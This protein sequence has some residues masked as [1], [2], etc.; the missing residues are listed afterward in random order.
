MTE[1]GMSPSPYVMT[2]NL[3]IIDHL[4]INLYSSIPAVISEA[5]A[6]AWDAD[7][8]TIEITFDSTRRA[9]VIGDNGCGMTLGEINTKFLTVGYRRRD[10]EPVRTPRDRHVM[11]RKGIGKLS[12]FSIAETIEVQTAKASEAGGAL[13]KNGLV[14]RTSE[15]REAAKNNLPYYPTPVPSAASLVQAGTR[16]ELTNLSIQPTA[17]TWAALRRRLARRFSVIGGGD[18]SIVVDGSP[19]QMS[20]RAYFEKV[21]YLWS[22]GDVGNRY[23]DLAT[24]KER[25]ETIDGTVD[26]GSG[27]SVRGWVGTFDERKDIDEAA[28]AVPVLAWGKLLHEDLLGEARA[29]GL[30]TKYLTGEIEAD[31]I[32]LDAEPD[33]VTSDRQRLKEDDPRVEALATWFRTKVL[34]QVGNSWRDW[35]RETALDSALDLPPI[36]DWYDALN[37][38]EK[39]FAKQLFGKIGTVTLAD[40]E[41]R[42]ELYR[43]AI[44]AF[45]RLRLKSQLSKLANLPEN[46][47]FAVLEAVFGGIDEIEGAQYHQIARVR[48][49]VIR[50]F[51]GI[52]EAEREKLIQR[53]LFGH[54]WLLDPSWERASTNARIEEAVTK[55]FDEVD[56]SLTEEERRGRVD[57]RYRTAAGKH[58]IIE[59]KKYDVSVDLSDLFRQLAK[60]R[61]AL[62]KCLTEKFPTEHQNIELIAILGKPPTGPAAT[63]ERIVDVLETLNA[64]YITYD[65]LIADTIRSYQDYLDADKEVSR[66]SDILDRLDMKQDEVSDADSQQ[67]RAGNARG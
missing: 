15:I 41:A 9:I 28:N 13:E 18:F 42:R 38:D 67:L 22:I 53:Y 60:Y 36:K 55:E 49:D 31:F 21:Q 43:H 51:V 20:E 58:I 65:D 24:N 45:E 46:P 6:N 5:V 50:A 35:R 2:L 37:H 26:A 1:I 12:L 30:Y 61:S 32:D 16:I 8:T 66:I 56:A 48:L 62:E 10:I 27:Y 19:I 40:A 23:V 54:L 44:L 34:N 52:V 25:A 14:M 63:P 17:A 59:L 33:I 39:A 3:S 47:D 57:I 11:G 29:G 7:A 4:G 64:R